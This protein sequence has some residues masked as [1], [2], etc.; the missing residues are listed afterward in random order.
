MY[1]GN[2][3]VNRCKSFSFAPV[4]APFTEEEDPIHTF[5]ILNPED[6]AMEAVRNGSK[7]DT[8]VT[9]PC[10]NNHVLDCMCDVPF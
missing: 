3:I 1:F 8:N 5:G 7:R 4:Q 10:C 6:I 2:S 9:M